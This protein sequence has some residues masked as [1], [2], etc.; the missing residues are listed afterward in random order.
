VESEDFAL[1][2]G[3]G[4][5]MKYHTQKGA[6][7]VYGWKAS[8]NPAYEFHGEPDQKPRKMFHFT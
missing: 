3:E 6:E 5:E 8:A 2:P 1:S 4:M 7:M